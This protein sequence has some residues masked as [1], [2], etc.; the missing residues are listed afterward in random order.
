MKQVKIQEWDINN[1]W[2]KIFN[3]QIIVDHKFNTCQWKKIEM[4]VAIN[5]IVQAK[6][7]VAVL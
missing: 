2:G 4:R 3:D 6:K 5:F 1:D 7:K